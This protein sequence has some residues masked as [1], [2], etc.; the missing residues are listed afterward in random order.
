[1]ARRATGVREHELEPPDVCPPRI[2]TT[3]REDEDDDNVVDDEDDEDEGD[4]PPAPKEAPAAFRLAA[5]PPPP[6]ALAFSKDV[7]PAADALLGRSLLFK[8]PVIGWCVGQIVSRNTDARRLAKQVDGTSVKKTFNIHY[9][10]DDEEA[11]TVLDAADYDGD[12][13]GSWVL[14]ETVDTAPNSS[15]AAPAAPAAPT[16][17]ATA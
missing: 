9:E 16:P 3:A 14:L 6:E 4:V 13:D 2:D 11:C 1:M 17:T 15:A 7:S 5:S 12:E 8:W 10:I